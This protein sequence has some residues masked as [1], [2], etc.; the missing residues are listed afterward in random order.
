MVGAE[1]A[2]LSHKPQGIRRR[3][4]QHDDGRTQRGAWRRARC[5]CIV[6]DVLA[7]SGRSRVDDTITG[8]VDGTGG[9]NGGAARHALGVMSVRAVLA[10]VFAL[11]CRHN[12]FG[13]TSRPE[14]ILIHSQKSELRRTP[15]LTIVR[16]RNSL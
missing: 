6:H 10:T 11:F 4:P 2:L 1:A 15:V 9:C 12:S 5:L 16:P 8:A 7:S 13:R 14:R 3:R